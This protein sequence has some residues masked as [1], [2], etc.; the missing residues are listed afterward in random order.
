MIAFWIRATKWTR[1]RRHH[2][3]GA[4]GVRRSYLVTRQS[5]IISQIA[6][7][8][9]RLRAFGGLR[10]SPDKVPIISQ[11]AR[12]AARLR[13]FGGLRLSPCYKTMSLQIGLAGRDRFLIPFK[14]DARHARN[15]KQ[16]VTNFIGLL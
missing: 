2:H 7:Q 8:A 4:R 14:T 6:R 1:S 12:Q 11:I 15:V 9:A 3:L 5:P 13:A 10:L 16:S